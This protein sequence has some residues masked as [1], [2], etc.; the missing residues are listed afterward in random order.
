MININHNILFIGNY[1]TGK[2]SII[3]K[4]IHNTFYLDY[5]PSEYHTYNRFTTSYN[6][7]IHKYHIWE[8]SYTNY[9][10]NNI[11]I[12]VFV[13]DINELDKLHKLIHY[14]TVIHSSNNNPYKIY[15]IGN[16]TDL[17]SD[18]LN[19]QNII[20]IQS[21]LNNIKTLYYDNIE[22]IQ[23][24][25]LNN[26]NIN[27]LFDSIIQTCINKNT[28]KKC[29]IEMYSDSDSDSDNECCTCICC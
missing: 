19:T 22:F 24:S 16:K 13:F 29:T 14:I 21:F 3:N 8:T 7:I 25:T 4:Y 11:D 1:K 9:Y 6:N 2:T 20:Y 10:I 27:Y 26:I 15:I 18:C 17:L 28:L 12:I 5:I 23:T